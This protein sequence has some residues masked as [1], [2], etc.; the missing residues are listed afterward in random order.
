MY[1]Q[2]SGIIDRFLR[3]KRSLRPSLRTPFTDKHRRSSSIRR[4]PREISRYR[5]RTGR[6]VYLCACACACVLTV[7]FL[8]CGKTERV[9]VK[10]NNATRRGPTGATGNG[11]QRPLRSVHAY[12]AARHVPQCPHARA[13]DF[14]RGRPYDDVR[15]RRAVSRFSRRRE[16][17]FYFCFILFFSARLLERARERSIF[18]RNVNHNNNNITPDTSLSLGTTI[19]FGRLVISHRRRGSLYRRRRAIIAYNN[20]NTVR[21]VLRDHWFFASCPGRNIRVRSKW[22]AYKRGIIQLS[23][24]WPVNL[25]AAAVSCRV[26]TRRT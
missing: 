16:F 10:I 12:V 8:S 5:H 24:S 15:N 2:I 21:I 14:A 13:R 25:C 1:V 4:R 6:G 17:G 22:Y 9:H 18:N 23:W 20:N 3:V 11:F 19:T 26:V 7:D